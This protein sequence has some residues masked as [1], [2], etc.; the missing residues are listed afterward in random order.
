[1]LL[2]DK[3]QLKYLDTNM[4]LLVE[5]SKKKALACNR[6]KCILNLVIPVLT[7]MSSSSLLMTNTYNLWQ[8]F[9]LLCLL[10][11]RKGICWHAHFPVSESP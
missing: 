6:I 2:Y 8:N 11:Q 7:V 4:P 10:T 1:M 5:S 9:R 3:E